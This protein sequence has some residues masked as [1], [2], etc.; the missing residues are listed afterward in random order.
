MSAEEKAPAEKQIGAED[1]L[2]IPALDEM[3][4]DAAADA[5]LQVACV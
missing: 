5:F 1:L 2:K 3:T 4:A